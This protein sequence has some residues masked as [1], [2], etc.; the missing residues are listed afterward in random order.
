MRKRLGED[1][2]SRVPTMRSVFVVF[3]IVLLVFSAM[4]PAIV[5]ANEPGDESAQQQ[6]TEEPTIPA[7]TTATTCGRRSSA[8]W[9]TNRDSGAHSG[10][11]LV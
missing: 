9:L 1:G 4:G 8:N 2:S 3:Q 7:P 10:G 5:L 6:A 11:S